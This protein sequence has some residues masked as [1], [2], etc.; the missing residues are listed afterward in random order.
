MEQSSLVYMDYCPEHDDSTESLG[1]YDDGHCHCFACGFHGF[2]FASPSEL[3]SRRRAV[4][5]RTKTKKLEYIPESLVDYYV[6]L[7]HGEFRERLGWLKSRGFTDDTIRR[8][9]FGHTGN[10]FSIPVYSAGGELQTVRYRRDDATNPDGPKYWGIRGANGAALYW[11]AGRSTEGDLLLC[12]GEYDAALLAQTLGESG[13]RPVSAINGNR[14]ITAELFGELEGHNTIYIAYD[15]DKAG[16]E[17]HTHLLALNR[18][19]FLDLKRVVWPI[20]D[21]KDVTEYLLNKGVDAFRQRLS[22]AIP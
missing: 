15:Q 11:P 16:D 13:S 18:S 8:L 1:V 17:G 14:G 21:G 4:V 19:G 12:E 22:E 2:D 5:P 3:S 7:L 10:G 6:E 9:R 20:E